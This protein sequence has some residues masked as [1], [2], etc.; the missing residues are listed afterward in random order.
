MRSDYNAKILVYDIRLSPEKIRVPYFTKR[1]RI[2]I[3]TLSTN[4]SPDMRGGIPTTTAINTLNDRR[5]ACQRS[6]LGASPV[7]SCTSTCQKVSQGYTR[8]LAIS[9]PH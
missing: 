1:S 7:P 9:E 4:K 2:E 3:I 5:G 6:S 8:S